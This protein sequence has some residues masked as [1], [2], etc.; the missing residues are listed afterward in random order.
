MYYKIFF[1]D[2]SFTI[3]KFNG[4]YCNALDYADEHANGREFVIEEHWE[5]DEDE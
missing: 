2:G 1:D 5:G 4:S 3:G